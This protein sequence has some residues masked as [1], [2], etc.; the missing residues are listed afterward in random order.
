MT[1]DYRKHV[2][3][4]DILDVFNLKE[5]YKNTNVFLLPATN[6]SLF[7]LEDIYRFVNNI[8]K[9]NKDFKFIFDVI[10][11]ENL[12]TTRPQKHVTEKGTFYDSNHVVDDKICYN[13]FHKES[14]TLGYSLKYNHK[15]DLLK[16]TLLSL[17]MKITEKSYSNSYYMI[18]GH[19]NSKQGDIYATNK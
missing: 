16:D 15:I 2:I 8:I 1:I 3:N 6:I 11:I 7:S 12:I 19:Y 4:E 14:N 18:I 13:V 9:I 10:D 5:Y 17:N